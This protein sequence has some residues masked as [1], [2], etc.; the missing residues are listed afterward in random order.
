MLQEKADGALDDAKRNW[1][2]EE[3]TMGSGRTSI[4]AAAP[5]CHKSLQEH[6]RT[7]LSEKRHGFAREGHRDAHR[8]VVALQK[9]GHSGNIHKYL[10]SPSQNR[11]Y[12]EVQ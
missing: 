8:G 6:L 2:I 12:T 4:C 10:E 9:D 11:W 5:E 3:F 7:A 1:T